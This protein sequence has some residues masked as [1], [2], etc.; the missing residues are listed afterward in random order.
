MLST[1]S[2]NPDVLIVLDINDVLAIRNPTQIQ[3][4]N[5]IDHGSYYDDWTYLRPSKKDLKVERKEIKLS[6]GSFVL[7]PGA[8]SFLRFCKEMGDVATFTST[9]YQNASRVVHALSNAQSFPQKYKNKSYFKFSW[10]RDRT[11]IDLNGE[12]KWCTTK[13]IK[14][15]IDNPVIN[16]QLKYTKTNI[17]ICDDSPYKVRFNPTE[18]VVIVRPIMDGQWDKNRHLDRLAEDIIK[19]INILSSNSEESTSASE[20]PSPV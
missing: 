12:E 18:N 4:P 2:T 15:I 16:Q 3:V 10:Y 13:H 11:R 7:C 20:S 19:Q 1:T 14:D 17:V 6:K 9:T 5:P 8:C